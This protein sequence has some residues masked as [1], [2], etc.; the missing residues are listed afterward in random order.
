MSS[1]RERSLGWVFFIG[2]SAAVFALF[3]FAWLADEMLK[4]DTRAFDQ[5]VRLAFNAHA[6]PALTAAMRVF[7]FLGSP[8]AVAAISGVVAVLFYYWR[9]RRALLLFVITLAGAAVL[10]ATLKLAFQRPRPP[11]TFFE[12]ATPASY[13]FPSGH[14]MLSVCLFGTLAVLVSPRLR[15]RAGQ[16]AVWLAA[17][18]LVLAIGLSRIYL[19]VHY[20][21][22]V[23]AGY[24]AA[25][26][27]VA[28]VALADHLL[29]RR[30][31]AR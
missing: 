30:R 15:S 23:I 12:T 5:S 4:G 10:N 26:V 20:P 11:D 18:A 28:A 3:V 6:S 19:G 31:V 1:E 16:V 14:A 21:S 25:V 9:W 13:S 24:A 22:D 7:T 2:L 17:I 29:R 27:W 8:V